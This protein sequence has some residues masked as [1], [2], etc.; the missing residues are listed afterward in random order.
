[1]RG[2]LYSTA[3]NH[4]ISESPERIHVPICGWFA[5][6]CD[7][8]LLAHDRAA[9]HGV[10]TQEG[11]G[12]TTAVNTTA[13]QTLLRCGRDTFALAL[14]GEARLLLLTQAAHEGNAVVVGMA[15]RAE[16]NARRGGPMRGKHLAEQGN[17]SSSAKKKGGR[18]V[19]S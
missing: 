2:R 15:L 16:K 14:L 8:G 13:Q 17:F 19:G 12:P 5:A 6:S 10:A 7:D 3:T 4:V 9:N 18:G 11:G 1:M